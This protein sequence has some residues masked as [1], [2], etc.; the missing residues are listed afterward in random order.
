MIAKAIT[1]KL[2]QNQKLQ[3]GL[4]FTV[5][6]VLLL[7]SLILPKYSLS[8]SD[9]RLSL[10]SFAVVGILAFYNLYKA[11]AKKPFTLNCLHWTFIL[12]FGFYAPIMQLLAEREPSTA[13]LGKLLKYHL[14]ANIVM[15]VWCVCYMIVYALLTQKYNRRQRREPQTAEV[16]DGRLNSMGLAMLC[17]LCL[18][19]IVGTFAVM[20]MAGFGTRANVSYS[21]AD[22]ASGLIVNSFL[23]YVP[24]AALAAL[25]LCKTKKNL[26]FFMG[27]AIIG[28]SCLLLD[29][30]LTLPRF[31]FA[32]VMVGFIAIFL[33]RKRITGLWLPVSVFIGLVVLMP[34]LNIGRYSSIDNI[35]MRNMDYVNR[36]YAYNQKNTKVEG[37]LVTFTSGDF[38]AFTMLA[39]TIDYVDHRK[40]ITYGE[41]LVGSLLF[42]VPR[43]VWKNKPLTSGELVAKGF[44]MK[45]RNLSNPLMAEGYLNFGMLGVIG[46][47]LITGALLARLDATYWSVSSRT[48]YL[49]LV[50]PFLCGFV[51]FNMRGSLMTTFAYMCGFLVASAIV[52]G[53]AVKAPFRRKKSLPPV[54]PRP[55]VERSN[56]AM[57]PSR[58]KK[59]TLVLESEA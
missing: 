55:R 20:G 42:F 16:E 13:A 1:S 58:P 26:G 31:Q 8:W 37:Y 59:R 5:F 46:F 11:A 3:Y 51:L 29:S 18:V 14:D 54:E 21:G 10:P 47:A 56:N 24:I 12:Y 27:L 6:A 35:S 25:L 36:T 52:V 39:N 48:F 34:I 7:L 30:P 50:Y 33:R 15:I 19:A 2:N 45:F 40:G 38:D 22:K 9:T 57:P 41:Q 17:G 43:Q 4:A 28:G 23:R 32:T 44:G 49:N 53:L